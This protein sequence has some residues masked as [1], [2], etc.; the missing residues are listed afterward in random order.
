MKTAAKRKILPLFWLLIAL[1]QLLFAAQ[2]AP[3]K[4]AFVPENHVWKIFPLAAESHQPTIAQVTEPQRERAPPQRSTV[5]GCVLGPETNVGPETS[6]A[7][8]VITNPGPNGFVITQ[9][10]PLLQG[11]NAAI[12]Q[13]SNGSLIYQPGQD[14]FVLVGNGS[15]SSGVTRAV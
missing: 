3:A 5:P 15:L 8:N 4:S 13:Q 11:P 10:G 6:L 2:L 7:S 1:F 12:A 9:E 14:G